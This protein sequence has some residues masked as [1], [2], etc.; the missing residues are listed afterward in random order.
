M[1]N[2]LKRYATIFIFCCGMTLAVSACNTAS[3]FMA[4]VSSNTSTSVPINTS[5]SIALPKSTETSAPT[6]NPQPR[7]T[8]APA[9]TLATLAPC[10][11]T[12]YDLI[13]FM[14]D[15]IR[16]LVRA[17]SGVQIFNLQTMKEEEFLQAPTNLNG[18]VVALSPN[19]EMLAWAL[20]DN[21]I[22]LIRVSDKKLLSA[23]KGHIG[24]I[25]KLRFSP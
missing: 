15:N 1:Y 18:P 19:G 8:L 23:L 21:T 3:S 6:T 14:P 25:T 9:D 24:S 10:F 11:V 22:Q 16:I 2:K 5:T 12:Y 20:E 17:N 4:P 7:D 13:A